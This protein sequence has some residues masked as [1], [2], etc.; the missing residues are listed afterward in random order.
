MNPRGPFLDKA[1]TTAWKALNALSLAVS[2]ELEAHGITRH[3]AELMYV[4]ASQM[5][6]CAFCLDLHSRQAR[7]AGVTQQKLDLLT[8]WRD[9]ELFSMREIAFL[10]IAEATTAL[11]VTPQSQAD[12]DDARA[13]LGDDV[14]AMAE[15]AALTI[16]AFN[17]VSILS[18]HPV[19]ERGADG[20]VMS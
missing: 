6:G 13:V 5:N 18:H 2:S 7:E 20:K 9:T 10:L 15:W 3:E 1:S 17:R 16:N 11:P 12:L 8:A 4:R 19:R 14:F